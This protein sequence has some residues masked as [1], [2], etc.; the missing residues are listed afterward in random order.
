MSSRLSTASALLYLLTLTACGGGGSL[1][2]TETPP[3]P[4]DAMAAAAK[5]GAVRTVAEARQAASLML[6]SLLPDSV[7]T[8]GPTSKAASRNFATLGEPPPASGRSGTPAKAVENCPGGGTVTDSQ[9]SN[10]DVD[11]PYTELPFTLAVLTYNLCK[12]TDEDETQTISVGTNGV[13]LSGSVTEGETEVDYVQ[14]GVSTTQPL[15][16]SAQYKSKTGVSPSFD[17]TINSENHGIFHREFSSEGVLSRRFSSF[18]GSLSGTEGGSKLDGAFFVKRGVSASD[19][20]RRDFGDSGS[21]Y[22]GSFSSALLSQP[23]DLT[24]ACGSGGTFTMST[25]T[26]VDD[27][28]PSEGQLITGTVRLSAAG[29]TATYVFSGDGFVEITAGDGGKT[30]ISQ[31]QLMNDCPVLILYQ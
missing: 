11:S 16:I 9:Q 6:P 31:N 12:E 13:Q 28:D 27:I 20:F 14:V 4:A 18:L 29:K 25:V 24:S 15:R 17:Y 3:T 30:T 19:L 21:V 23:A 1:E 22:E 7:T 2:E 26:P 5:T 10:V 8:S